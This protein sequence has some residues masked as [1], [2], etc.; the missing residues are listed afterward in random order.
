MYVDLHFIVYIFVLSYCL[1]L[2][3]VVNIE[4]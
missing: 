2:W 4:I 1:E 3:N